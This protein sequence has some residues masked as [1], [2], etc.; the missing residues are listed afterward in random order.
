M[1]AKLLIN[2]TFASSVALN[3]IESIQMD[4]GLIKTIQ[5]TAIVIFN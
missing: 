1:F 5:I 3:I 2:N 4:I